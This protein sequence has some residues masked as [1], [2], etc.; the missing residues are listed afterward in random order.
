MHTTVNPHRF[1]GQEMALTPLSRGQ[2]AVLLAGFRIG[3]VS[4][5][6]GAEGKSTWLWSMTGPHCSAALAT[7]RMCGEAS[8]LANAKLQLRHSFDQWLSWA[9]EQEGPVYW[10]WTEAA[11]AR[12]VR[13]DE[14]QA[15]AASG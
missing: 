10:H 11:P 15:L 12:S 8:S 13:S 4:H 7:L 3:R 9:L 6:A 5:V 14:T 1:I 2:S